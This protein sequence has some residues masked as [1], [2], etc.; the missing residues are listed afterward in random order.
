MKLEKTGGRGDELT[1]PRPHTANKTE[2]VTGDEL[3]GVGAL[4]AGCRGRPRKI[5]AESGGALRPAG[6]PVLAELPA[7][8]LAGRGPVVGD[9]FTQFLDVTLEVQLVLLEP[10]DVELLAGGTA[11]ELAGHVFFVIADDSITISVSVVQLHRYFPPPFPL[12]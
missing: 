12:F 7:E 11:L 4:C 6:R 10:A 5:V 9:V 1:Y 2:G 3:L 8:L